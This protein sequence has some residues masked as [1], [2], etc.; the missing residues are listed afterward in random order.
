MKFTQKF[1]IMRTELIAVLSNENKTVEGNKVEGSESLTH[2][3][4]IIKAF[5]INTSPTSTLWLPLIA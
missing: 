3:T 4:F 1:I 5:T 2:K